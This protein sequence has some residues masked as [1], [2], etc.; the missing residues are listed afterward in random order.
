MATTFNAKTIKKKALVGGISAIVIIGFFALVHVVYALT[1]SGLPSS[2][3]VGNQYTITDSVNCIQGQIEIGG[4]TKTCPVF[5]NG[6]NWIDNPGTGGGG[7]S[8]GPTGPAGPIGPTGPTGP[9]GPI[10][11]TGAGI[12]GPVGATGLTGGA[13]PAGAT[14]PV[15]ATGPIGATGLTGPGGSNGAVGATGLT[16]PAGPT[17]PAGT[18]G[19]NGAIGPTGPTGPAGSGAVGATGPIGPTGPTGAA[20]P[21][22]PT[23]AGVAGPAGPTGPIGPGGPAGP[24][25]IGAAGPAGATGPV[26][27]TGIQGPI[28]LT[29]SAGPTGLTGPAG[30]TGPTGLTGPG[31]SNGAIGAT[32]PIGP[33]GPAGSAG[34]AGAIGATGPV[35]LTGP[36]GP[37]GATGVTGGVGAT[38]P[39]GGAGPVGPTGLTGPAGPTGVTG[40]TGPI[41]PTGSVGPAG[42][43]GPA[44][45]PGATGRVYTDLGSSVA[46]QSQSV[47]WEPWVN[48]VAPAAGNIWSMICPAAWTFPINF[49]GSF[50]DSTAVVKCG[51]NPPEN[52]VYPIQVNNVVVGSLKLTSACAATFNTAAVPAVRASTLSAPNVNS[53][54]TPTNVSGDLLLWFVSSGAVPT[55]PTSPS[56]W[57]VISSPTLDPSSAAYLTVYGLVSNG[58]VPGTLALPSNPTFLSMAVV[59]VQNPA[60]G[61]TVDAK[62]T[63]GGTSNVNQNIPATTGLSTAQGLLLGAFA[64]YTTSAAPTGPLTQLQYQNYGSG[65]NY[66]LWLGKLATSAGSTTAQ[67]EVFGSAVAASAVSVVVAPAAT[68]GLAVS[69]PAGQIMQVGPAPTPVTGLGAGLNMVLG[70][71]Y[72]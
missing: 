52:A 28:G 49:T 30:P 20:G 70:G 65:T 69:C 51:T 4:G 7:G 15:G 18:A 24:T 71:H 11:P 6:V 57:T 55:T 50:P 9:T 53:I 58:S 67:T 32:G 54:T 10:G 8:V 60:N 21:I 16:G 62:V 5:W 33:T 56:T 61:T 22:G 68:A 3:L 36:A 27:A 41:G 19:S 13:G 42:A 14:G 72:P 45:A 23:G 38:G 26:G 35:G 64:F 43:T 44:P 34:S 31:G 66:G 2:P 29:G 63:G 37:I 40:A 48:G 1:F 25:G 39:V 17:G 59:A 12:Q 46:L 47:A